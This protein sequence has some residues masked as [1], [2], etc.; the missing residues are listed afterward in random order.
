MLIEKFIANYFGE[1]T[2]LV[3]RSEFDLDY[4]PSRHQKR[5]FET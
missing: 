3:E 5:L 4:V 1:S 2:C